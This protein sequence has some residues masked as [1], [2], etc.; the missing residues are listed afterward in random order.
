MSYSYERIIGPAQSPVVPV[1][2]RAAGL[3]VSRA[4]SGSA[5]LTPRTRGFTALETSALACGPFGTAPHG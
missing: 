5:A 2:L 4:D 1:A 3:R